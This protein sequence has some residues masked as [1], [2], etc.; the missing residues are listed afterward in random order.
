MRDLREVQVIKLL[1]VEKGKKG[2]TLVNFVCGNRVLDQL[3]LAV[4]H[5]AKLTSILK[6]GR[7]D[8]ANNAQNAINKMKLAERGLKTTLFDLAKLEINEYKSL[9]KNS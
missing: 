8:H 7:V 6:G 3:Q 1:S 4:E 9:E 2:K 5:Q